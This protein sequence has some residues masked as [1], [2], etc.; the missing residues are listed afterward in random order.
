M[1]NKLISFIIIC[2]LILLTLM[3]YLFYIEN[4]EYKKEN[5]KLKSKN[6]SN[7]KEYFEKLDSLS[8]LINRK[9]QHIKD[10]ES[11]DSKVSVQGFKMNNRTI[12]V[13]ELLKIVNQ[14]LE[15]NNSLKKQNSE[16]KQ[17]IDFIEKNYGI[18]TRKEDSVYTFTI[19]PD[20]EL[21]ATEDQIN[22]DLSESQKELEEKRLVL[23][24]I[25]EKYGI[26]FNV[27]R[28]N[29]KIISTILITKADSAMWLYPYYKH[30]IKTNRNGET[31][32]K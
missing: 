5:I 13:K 11:N 8:L 6:E 31:V 1:K 7:Q 20:S 25:E 27:T 10:I 32:I 14:T 30:K 18:E 12:S 16:Y 3:C 26:K 15:E 4:S 2:L 19:K 21:K 23:Q 9:I 29:G 22:N 28:K 17:L 24:H